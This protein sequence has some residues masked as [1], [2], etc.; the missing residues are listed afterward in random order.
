MFT[1]DAKVY[2]YYRKYVSKTVSLLPI[3]LF[4]TIIPVLRGYID[5]QNKQAVYIRITT[6]NKRVYRITKIKVQPEE[7]EGGKVKD[8]H[9]K[10]KTFNFLLKKIVMEAEVE[11]AMPETKYQDAD[12]YKY[13]LDCLNEWDKTKASETHRQY[14]SEIK[15]LKSF[16]PAVRLTTITPEWLNRYKAFCFSKKNSVNTVHKNLKFVRLIVRKAQKEGLIERNPFDIFEMPKYRDP[17]KKYLTREEVES[18]EKITNDLELPHEIRFVATWF[19]IG[20]HTGLRF[21]DMAQFD[22]RKHIINNRLILYT[23]KTGTPVGMPVSAKL[24]ALFE[25]IN[26]KGVHITNTH[27][28]RILKLV[29]GVCNLGDISAHQSRHTFAM[30]CAN[31]GISQEVTAKLLGQTSLK[32]TAIYYKISNLRIDDE[33]KKL[34]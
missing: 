27:Y 14:T 8:N 11:A 20:C 26:Y 16:A 2:I 9:P 31:A 10:H 6:G 4:M 28:N 23:V 34:E 32:S 22:K 18:I 30:A 1:C 19:V 33:L 25:L 21:S 24:R 13:C 3:L 17:E 12:F 7:W 15:K 29:A 5:S